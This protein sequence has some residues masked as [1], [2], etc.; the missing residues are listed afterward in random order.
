MLLY[1]PTSQCDSRGSTIMCAKQGSQYA[2]QCDQAYN[3]G[4][5]VVGYSQLPVRQTGLSAYSWTLCRLGDCF[6]MHYTAPLSGPFTYLSE[7]V[8]QTDIS[9][10]LL[11][12]PRIYH[13]PSGAT[14]SGSSA[15]R[16]QYCLGMRSPALSNYL[17]K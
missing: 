16:V 17:Q 4:T 2:V 8:E 3:P 10:D 13:F 11:A 12:R 6:I 9:F 7:L 1:A 5:A 15:V 14:C